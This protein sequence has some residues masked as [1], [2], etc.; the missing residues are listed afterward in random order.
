MRSRVSY[1][2]YLLRV[3]LTLARRHRSVWS[4]RRWRRVCRCGAELPCRQQHRVPINRG[5]WPDQEQPRSRNQRSLAEQMHEA[6]HNAARARILAQAE[7]ER[8][9]VEETTRAVPE[10]WWRRGRG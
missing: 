4:W 2:E 1:D 3:A 10:W 8:I 6:E 9:P 7:A 5:H